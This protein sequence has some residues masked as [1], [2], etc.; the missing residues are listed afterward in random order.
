LFNNIIDNQDSVATSG[1]NVPLNFLDET[2]PSGG[3]SASKHIT[4]PVTLVQDAVGLN[5]IFSAN[6]PSTAN[7]IVYY[8]TGLEGSILSEQTWTNINLTGITPPS[9]ENRDIFRDY[10]YLIGGIT[11]TLIPFTQF[12]LKI[13]M[14]STNSSKVPVIKDLRVTA[15]AV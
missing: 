10:N 14:N 5:V 7:I 6:R 9:D 11:G 15:L 8:R 4:V 12:Q 2:L 1:F 3:S 13:V